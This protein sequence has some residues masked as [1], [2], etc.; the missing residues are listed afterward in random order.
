MWCKLVTS[1]FG[2]LLGKTATNSPLKGQNHITPDFVRRRVGLRP[3]LLIT[4]CQGYE[5]NRPSAHQHRAWPCRVSMEKKIT[6]EN[7]SDHASE[8]CDESAGNSIPCL[9][10]ANGSKIQRE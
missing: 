10:N 7:S 1:E 8:V 9:A 2:F 3:T 6:H 4:P 5:I